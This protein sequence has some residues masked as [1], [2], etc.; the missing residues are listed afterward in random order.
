MEYL[1]LQA[2]APV[3]EI[4]DLRMVLWWWPFV[5]AFFKNLFILLDLLI[6]VTIIVLVYRLRALHGRVYEAVEEAI[7]SGKLSVARMKRKWTEAEELMNSERLDDR[8]TAV[9]RA[10][11][12]LDNVLKAA[13]FSGENLEKRLARIPENK[14]NFQDDLVWAYRFKENLLADPGFTP[15]AE[16]LKRAF[17][18]FERSLKEMTIL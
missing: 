2:A 4:G 8:K 7:A 16:E 15:E 9:V 10:E 17:Y 18:V 11:G 13:N 3:I 6:V 12:I 5:F 14:L 1:I